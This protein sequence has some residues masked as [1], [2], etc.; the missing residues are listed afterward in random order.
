MAVMVTPWGVECGLSTYAEHL[1]CAMPSGTMVAAE[2]VMPGLHEGRV[3]PTVPTERCWARTS[4]A[5][6]SLK[7]YAELDGGLVHFN[8]EYSLFPERRAFLALLD[9]LKSR[10]NKVVITFH[11]M[12]PVGVP[13]HLAF[14]WVWDA[15]KRADALLVHN[16]AAVY[17]AVESGV[18]VNRVHHVQHGTVLDRPLNKRESRRAL[19]LPLE[20]IIG[21]TVGFITPNKHVVQTVQAA[22]L[23]RELSAYVIAGWASPMDRSGQCLRCCE[24]VAAE[25]RSSNVRFINRFL[26]D[27]ELK[28]IY[29]ASD[30]ATFFYESPILSTSGAARY[31]LTYGL[32]TVTTDVPMLEDLRGSS[33]VLKP[34]ASVD[35]LAEAM[36]MMAA[37]PCMVASMSA[38][39]E[40]EARRT[41]WA[42]TARIHQRI[43]AEVMR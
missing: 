34:T 41:S 36:A 16:R 35:E 24:Q 39:A 7:R 37:C 12:N 42:E 43:Y 28:L 15:A 9:E 1:V 6:D 11:S 32:P 8:H 2:V 31:A 25:C 33:I 10:G 17:K 5:Y 40:R 22:K 21:A 13:G 3:Y 30:F 29:S 14:R 26:T 19:G 27:A 23:V 20:G 18:D 4:P 38:I